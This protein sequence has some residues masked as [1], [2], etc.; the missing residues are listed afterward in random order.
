MKPRAIAVASSFTHY[1]GG[2]LG[3]AVVIV[4]VCEGVAAVILC[5]QSEVED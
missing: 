1:I 2:I 3:V 5:V 4:A